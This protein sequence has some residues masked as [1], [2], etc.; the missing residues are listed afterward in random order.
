MQ[1][2]TGKA[3]AGTD[4]RPQ[5]EAG[6]ASED[7]WMIGCT[8]ARACSSAP[9]PGCD[10]WTDLFPFALA[11]RGC[12]NYEGWQRQARGPRSTRRWRPMCGGGASGSTTNQFAKFSNFFSLTLEDYF[13][14]FFDVLFYKNNIKNIKKNAIT[15]T[16]S[17]GGKTQFA[18]WM[19]VAAGGGRSSRACK[20]E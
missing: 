12:A 11:R 17:S 10:Q 7:R 19:T 14:N 2:Q 15:R 4:E 9:A 3:R 6:S 8:Q 20:S 1:R 16:S 18:L 5:A 13:C